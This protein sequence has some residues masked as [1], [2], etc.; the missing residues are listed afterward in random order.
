MTPLDSMLTIGRAFWIG[1]LFGLVGYV[2]ANDPVFA[3]MFAGVAFSAV[4]ADRAFDAFRA[5]VAE[6]LDEEEHWAAL[7]RERDERLGR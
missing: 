2:F 6:R 4:A 7:H 5:Y 1:A 3:R